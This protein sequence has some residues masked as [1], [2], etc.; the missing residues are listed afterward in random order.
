[1]NGVLFKSL[2][3]FTR[4]GFPALKYPA[5]QHRGFQA[6]GGGVTIAD[7]LAARSADIHWPDGFSPDTADMFA[8]NEIIINAPRHV[9]WRTLLRAEKWPE[10]YPNSHHVHVLGDNSNGLLADGSRF[11]WGTFGF[12]LVSTVAEF[13]P[14]SRLGWYG[15]A[16]WYHTW[17]LL[18]APVGC[19]VTMEE[20]GKGTDAATMAR[21]A[22]D[23]MHRGHDLW[24][25]TLKWICEEQS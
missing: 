6:R 12:D 23:R 15:G 10:W 1:M 3:T 14:E 2:V 8:H 18:D 20:A 24:N 22:P 13:V 7:D 5:P 19:H 25:Q 4:P 16:D 17:L 11:R 21:T 9:V